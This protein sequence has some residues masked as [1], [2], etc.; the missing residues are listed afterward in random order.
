MDYAAN[1]WVAHPE[2]FAD[3]LIGPAFGMKRTNFSDEGASESGGWREFSPS[4]TTACA[5]LASLVGH[6]IEM[7]P[8]EQVLGI[9]T[10]WVIAGMKNLKTIWNRAKGYL[11]SHA[12]CREDFVPDGDATVSG[13]VGATVFAEEMPA[14]GWSLDVDLGPEACREFNQ[15]RGMTPE[16]ACRLASDGTAIQ[17]GTVGNGWF[18]SATA[19][20]FVHAGSIAQLWAQTWRTLPWAQ[21]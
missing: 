6:I 10:G 14:L 1:L 21:V 15:G 2:A 9:D 13:F 12:M 18:K 20:T 17:V 11:P 5:T 4:I 19:G 8:K 16:E 3:S 7:C